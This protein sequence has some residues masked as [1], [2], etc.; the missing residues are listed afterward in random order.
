MAGGRFR[1]YFLRSSFSSAE[2]STVCHFITHP[3]ALVQEPCCKTQYTVKNSFIPER[4]VIIFKGPTSRL[5]ER[6]CFLCRGDNGA[7]QSLLF[8]VRCIQSAS[9]GNCRGKGRRL[10]RRCRRLRI[11][12]RRMMASF[13]AKSARGMRSGDGREGRLGLEKATSVPP[14]RSKGEGTQAMA[15]QTMSFEKLDSSAKDKDTSN[16]SSSTSPETDPGASNVFP[17]FAGKR[18]SSP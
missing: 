13:R 4:G 12:R 15:W 10:A 9:R 11:Y 3:R 14:G 1:P 8:S 2:R 6:F 18:K 7:T 5:R 16:C 17:L